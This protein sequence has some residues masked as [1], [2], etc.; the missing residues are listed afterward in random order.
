MR[1]YRYY[2]YFFIAVFYIVSVI[3]VLF[4]TGVINRNP[5]TDE[6]GLI[7]GLSLVMNVINFYLNKKNISDRKISGTKMSGRLAVV[8]I[9]SGLV[10]WVLTFILV[11][12]L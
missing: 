3:N 11:L 2:T 1:F 8:F 7:G 12:V 6:I 10:L 9:V 4:C 5:K